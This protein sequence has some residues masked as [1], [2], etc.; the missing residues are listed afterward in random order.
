MRTRTVSIKIFPPGF[1]AESGRRCIVYP[2]GESNSYLKFRKLLFYP[3]NYRGSCFQGTKLMF[4]FEK[5]K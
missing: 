5:G 4:K 1:H 2:E 3:L